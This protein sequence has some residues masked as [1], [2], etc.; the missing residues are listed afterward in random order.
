MTD[1]APGAP[2]IAPTWSS[3]DKDAVTTALGGS[4]LWATIGHGVLNEVYWPST[5]EPRLRD[6]TFYLVGEG[7]WIDLK[8]EAS[9]A[10]HTPDPAVPLVTARH[11]SGEGEGAWTCDLTFLP[12]PARDALLVRYAVTGPFRLV[13][14]A[15]PHMEPGGVSERAWVAD[16]ACFAS[17]R[18]GEAACLLADPPVRGASVGFVGVSDGWQDLE[19]HGRTTWRHVEAGRGNLALTLDAD[20]PEGTLA[21]AFALDDVGAATLARSS[22]ASGFERTSAR[23][24]AGWEAWGAALGPAGEAGFLGEGDA[25][26]REALVRS[27]CVLKTHE[28]RSFPGALVASLSVPWGASTDTLGGYHLVWPR[29]ASMVA[30]ALIACGLIEDARAI[31]SHQLATQLPDGSW[32]Q[33]AFPSGRPFWTGVQLDQAAFPI[34]LAAKLSEGRH[35]LPAGTDVMVRRAARFVARAGP[36]TQQDRW[37]EN[38]GINPFTVAVAVAGLV[39]ATPWLEEEEAGEALALADEWRERLDAWCYVTRSPWTERLGVSGHYVRLAPD[40]DWHGGVD[41]VALGNRE[42]ERIDAAALV[43]MEFT[44]LPRLGLMAGDDPRL[45]ATAQ[46]VDAVLATTTPSGTVYHRYNQDGYGEHPDGSAYDGSGVGRA[47]PLLSGERG[48]LALGLGEDAEVHFRTMLRCAGRGGLLPEQVWDAVPIPAHG[49]APGRP[50]GSAMPLLWS[51]AE[52][53]KLAVALRTGRPAERLATVEARYRTPRPA[54]AYRWRD[55]TPVHRLP[56]SRCLIVEDEVPFVLHYGSDGWNDVREA[57]ATSGPF[58]LYRVVLPQSAMTGHVRLDFTRRRA[59]GW[60]GRDHTVTLEG[61]E[62]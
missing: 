23:F 54:S 55:R 14:I 21:L 7:G 50:S 33:N 16:G 8:R 51:H 38:P 29:D 53:V 4:R 49:L 3:S 9:Y 17:A 12:D 52:L 10:L 6:L 30:F 22:L 45:I 18:T 40:P 36:W 35:E 46:V 47:W 32:S 1:R 27:A 5:G 57:E 56:A 61:D 13:A 39:A 43:A 34:L 42:G 26:V 25:E 24:R 15:A 28:D 62:G 20:G 60:E 41:Q 58:G 37:E 11:A 31:L 19:A 44:W 59:D 2:G 48:H